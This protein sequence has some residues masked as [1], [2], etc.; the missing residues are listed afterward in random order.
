MLPLGYKGAV[1]SSVDTRYYKE[2]ALSERILTQ[3]AA[4]A[5]GISCRTG[6]RA[7]IL[8]ALSVSD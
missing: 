1:M 7:C 3:K 6:F 5:Y 2:R 4:V 8:G